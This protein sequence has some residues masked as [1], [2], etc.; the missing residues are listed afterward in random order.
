MAV[1]LVEVDNVATVLTLVHRAG[2]AGL[3]RA[4]LAGATGLNRST[5][6]SIV[7]ELIDHGLATEAAPER[8]TGVGRPSLIVT[9]TDRDVAIAVNPE[10]DAIRVAAVTLDGT[11]IERARVATPPGCT[12]AEAVTLT[13]GLIATVQSRLPARHR[14]VGVGVAVPGLVR[15][16]DG[17]VRLAPRLGWVERP[18]AEPL[19]ASLGLPVAAANDATIGMLAESRFGAARGVR[20]AIYLNG[21]ASGIGAGV[22]AGGV[23]LS[24]SS[25]YA[26]ELGHTLV[27]SVGDRCECG[28]IG[29]LE[30]EVRRAPLLRIAGI[31]ESEADTLA[32]VLAAGESPE[33]VAEVARQLQFLAVAVRTAVNVFNPTL[34]VLGGFLAA[35]HAADPTRLDTAMHGHALAPADEAVHIVGA[36]LGDDLLL[37][38]AAEIAFASLLARGGR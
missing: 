26:G 38:G 23:T 24:G 30:T 5:I 15:E 6:A 31:D 18:F 37:I 14:V 20:D 12:T 4:E 29:C 1:T 21:G 36:Q 32:G 28:A 19:A 2:A 16:S 9:L 35:L 8:P 27:N 34:I 17:F 11:I 33:L 13:A 10:L 25:G 22:V 3:S 7:G